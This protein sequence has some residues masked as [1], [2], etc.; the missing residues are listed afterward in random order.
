MRLALLRKLL[1]D[2]TSNFLHRQSRKHRT[3]LGR[4]AVCDLPQDARQKDSGKH[5]RVTRI[6][7]P[8]RNTD[9][10]AE[11]PLNNRDEY[12]GTYGAFVPRAL[13][14]LGIPVVAP[15]KP[16]ENFV[17]EWFFDDGGCL[18]T[19]VSYSDFARI[20]DSSTGVDAIF[21]Q[22]CH[23]TRAADA[24]P[25]IPVAPGGFGLAVAS[26]YGDNDIFISKNL[27]R[28]RQIK[29]QEMQATTIFFNAGH[30]RTV[31]VTGPDNYPNRRWFRE[32]LDG[33]P[34][35]PS[36]LWLE[37]AARSAWVL[38]LCGSGNSI[39]RKVVEL[40][41]IGCAIV[42]DRG[43]EDLELPYGKRFVHGENVWFV[44]DPEDLLAVPEIVVG[45]VWRRLVDGSRSLY[46]SC[47]RPDS[48]GRW[49]L[50]MAQEWRKR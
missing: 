2:V 14:T 7:C 47:F 29:D 18:R 13:Q 8:L 23:S 12:W 41:A 45:E 39:D 43:L 31:G 10:I 24:M 16:A 46:E 33:G 11:H 32:A 15:A 28:L 38:N 6:V 21:K 48:L 25:P 42:S 3:G 5:S 22:R 27:P 36:G 37:S 17:I 40:C 4:G 26:S 49:Y 44:D 34:V 9:F 20:F 19:G 50:A 35:Q 1:R 30:F